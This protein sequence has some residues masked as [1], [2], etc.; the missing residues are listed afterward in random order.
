[1]P[2]GH[3]GFYKQWGYQQF[4]QVLEDEV[5]ATLL[6]AFESLKAEV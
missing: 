5:R 4:A 6:A 3:D 1:M 2:G